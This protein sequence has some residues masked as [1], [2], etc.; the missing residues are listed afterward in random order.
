[1]PNTAEFSLRW[2]DL[3]VCRVPYQVFTDPAV[4]AYEQE[5]IFR[6]DTWQWVGLEI[7]TP[8]PGDFKTQR[9]GDTPVIMV[10]DAQ[11]AIKVFVNRCCPSRCA[12]LHRATRHT[13]GS[14]PVRTITGRLIWTVIYAGWRFDTVFVTREAYRQISILRRTA[15]S[16]CGSRC[17]TG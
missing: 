4:Y 3:G 2:P 9:L 1:M 10:R 16:V 6:G 17:S 15:C 7:E 14:L 13:P 5:R 11:G 12:A 8:N